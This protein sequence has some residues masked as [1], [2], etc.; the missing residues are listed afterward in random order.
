METGTF[1][2]IRNGA[3]WALASL[4]IP[5]KE[6]IITRMHALRPD[7][8]SLETGIHSVLVDQW[9]WERVIRKEDRSINELKAT[10][11]KIY[12]AIKTTASELKKELDHDII[13]ADDVTFIHTEELIKRYPDKSPKEREHL[14]C[15]E[16]GTVFLIGIGKILSE[17]IAH[18]GR[19]PDYDDWSS[20]N[21]D[22][23][24][25]LNGDLLV[26]HEE[27]KCAFELS[28]MGIRVTPEVLRKQLEICDATER[29][30]LTWHKLLLE[31]KLP[32][33]IGGGIGQSRLCQFLLKEKH[34]GAV[35][36][37]AWPDH[38]IKKCE[39]EKITL[40]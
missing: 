28:S 15:K 8:E 36:P 9:D 23:F 20:K 37:S 13:L 33:T 40:L 32:T 2:P 11:K 19:A 10:V 39:K 34:I 18:D 24:Y 16:F 1:F 5:A 25:G 4:E 27:L 12:S 31:G 29:A 26:W 7:E 3:A 22:G 17:G 38:I 30:T 14:V 35:Q 6:G 21:E